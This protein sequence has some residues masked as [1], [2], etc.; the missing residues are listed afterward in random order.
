MLEVRSLA[1]PDVKLIRTDRFSDGRG[2]FC[3][4]FQRPA[5]AGLQRCWMPEYGFVDALFKF[6]VEKYRCRS[7][8]FFDVPSGFRRRFASFASQS[9]LTLACYRYGQFTGD[10]GAIEMAMACTHHLIKLQGPRGSWPWFFTPVYALMSG[11]QR[12]C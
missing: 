6:L 7:D 10:L 12:M 8:L 11:A 5:F 3:E 1:I 4:T 2:Y 9:Y